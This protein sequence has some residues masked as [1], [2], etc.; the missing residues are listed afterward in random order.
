[1]LQIPWNPPWL[2]IFL[3]FPSLPNMCPARIRL[4]RYISPAA[5]NK[6][7]V[8]V[9]GEGNCLNVAGDHLA[10]LL[11]GGVEGLQHWPRVDMGHRNNHSVVSSLP[12]QALIMVIV[13]GS[14]AKMVY[15]GHWEGGGRNW[16]SSPHVGYFRCICSYC[17]E[18]MLQ[19]L[20]LLHSV[21]INSPS[22][23]VSCCFVS[24]DLTYSFILSTLF[25]VF[26]RVLCCKH[27]KCLVAPSVQEKPLAADVQVPLTPLPHQVLLN[28]ETS[29]LKLF[30]RRNS[31][32]N[33]FSPVL[34]T[35]NKMSYRYWK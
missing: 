10:S 25:L 16:H 2:F 8:A 18:R 1:M 33:F 28:H 22:P 21:S 20:P 26:A 17:D 11:C 29:L 19:F 27:E 4:R 12:S 9:W 24:L 35:E 14:G 6:T 5:C 34:D 31:P 23:A 13:K 30:H 7:G 3:W 32:V 15:G